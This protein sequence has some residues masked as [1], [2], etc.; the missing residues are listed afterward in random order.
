MAGSTPGPV[1]ARV[2]V[3]LSTYNGATYIVEQLRSILAQ[4]PAGGRVWVRDD[5]SQ[6]DT[7]A[8]IQALGDAR[9][10]VQQGRNLG[11]GASFLSLLAQVPADVDL[12]LFSDQDDVWLPG[13]LERAWAAL[14]PLGSTPGLYGS[15]Q[16][17]ADPALRP[18]HATQPWPRGPSLAGALVENTIT[19]CT[20]ALNGAAIRLLQRAGVPAGVRFHDWWAY[21]VV[22]AF[23]VVLHDAEPT[24]L[25]RQHG[26]NQIGHGAGWLGR[27]R[28]IVRFL[29]RHDWVGILLAQV[30]ALRLHYGAT[31]PGAA[32]ALI[33]RY[34]NFD[35]AGAEASW[36]LIFSPLRW[37]QH[38]RDEL[39]LRI[40]L[41]AHKLRLWPPGPRRLPP[42][43]SG[44]TESL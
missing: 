30:W 16:M 33:S 41:A 28:Q 9:I 22:S 18:L 44:P 37:R 10:Q 15:A 36:R 32:D 42:M 3:L 11:F 8:R 43:A 17:L 20:A 27:Q 26:A 29:L 6:D 7:T 38:L 40:L 5:G 21:L 2:M 35:L 25:Y 4:L 31:L 19:G 13:K 39:P 12:V 14:Q 24:L 23:G 1:A 34:F